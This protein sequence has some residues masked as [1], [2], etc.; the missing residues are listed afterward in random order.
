[1]IKSS[2]TRMDI[3]Y[4]ERRIKKAIEEFGIENLMEY[5]VN[6]VVGCDIS[7]FYK[8]VLEEV[9]IEDNYVDALETSDGKYE[10]TFEFEGKDMWYISSH[11]WDTVEII[12]E[13][14][15]ENVI[16]PHIKRGR[17]SWLNQSIA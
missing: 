15:I 8:T 6:S 2:L 3:E 4:L 12:V 5:T 17:A 16:I 1:M 11:A 7:D 14:L 13:N 10:L 9:L